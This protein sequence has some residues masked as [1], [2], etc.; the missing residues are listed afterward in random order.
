MLTIY[1]FDL[2]AKPDHPDWLDYL[3]LSRAQDH[4]LLGGPGWDMS[5]ED[6]LLLAHRGIERNEVHRFLAREEGQAVGFGTLES[7]LLDEPEAPNAFVYVSPAHRGRGIGRA[8]ADALAQHL[9]RMPAVRVRAWVMAPIAVGESIRPPSDIG[10]APAGHPGI[11]L[12]LAF[13]F[14]LQQIERVSRLDLAGP[15]VESTLAQALAESAACAG[16]DYEMVTFAGAVP[17]ELLDDVAMLYQRMSTDPPQGGLTVIESSWD[18]ARVQAEDARLLPQF[19]RWRAVVRHRPSAKA[20]AL[21]EL[22]RGRENPEAL[23]EQ[24]DTIVL[25]AFRGNRLG[26]WVKAANLI[27]LRAADPSA[28][29]VY[30]WNAEEN[31]YMLDVNEALGFR[32]VLVEAAFERPLC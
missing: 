18:A 6:A 17:E 9:E 19:H 5:P 13:G 10:A 32:P 15:L 22:A 2:P 23:V 28:E 29:C 12:A 1:P 4:E 31:R 20:V 21:T 30:T 8:L 16:V 14:T 3:G 24:G 11:R 26:M 7:N 27:Q 25:P